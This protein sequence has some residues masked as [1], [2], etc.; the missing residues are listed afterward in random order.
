MVSS[1]N[2]LTVNCKN[3]VLPAAPNS[4]PVFTSTLAL[5]SKTVAL[6][7]TP[8]PAEDHNGII[9]KYIINITAL[10]T[11][12]N[13]QSQSLGT[14]GIIVSLIPSF[15]YNFSV[16]AFTVSAGPYSSVVTINMPEDG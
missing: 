7:W 2:V 12:A 10:Q 3:C 9:R 1:F 15:T 13:F 14:L 16:T 6:H 4:P 8:P 11:G 5:N